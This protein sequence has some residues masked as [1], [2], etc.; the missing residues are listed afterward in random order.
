MI[1]KTMKNYLVLFFLVMLTVISLIIFARTPTTLDGSDVTKI[2]RQY[3][4]IFLIRHGERCDRSQNKCLSAT[5]GITVNGANKAR[6]YGKV[7]NKMFPSYGLYSTDT[8]RTVQTAIFF[9]GGKKPTIPE[10]STFDNDAINNILKISEHNK[11]TVIFTHNHCLSRIAK[12][13]NGWR[14]KP[15]YMDTLV[16]HRKNNHLILNGNLKSDN[17]LH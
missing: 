15:D 8:P 17:L 9:S 13:M 2:S 10:I 6:Q 1:N 16:L 11:V 7:F 12:K 5:E 14:L 3:P 4:T